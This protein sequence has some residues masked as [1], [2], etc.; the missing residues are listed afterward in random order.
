[1]Q[2][3]PRQTVLGQQSIMS[4]ATL[5]VYSY[6]DLPMLLLRCAVEP[7]PHASV[8]QQRWYMAKA[9]GCPIKQGISAKG[10]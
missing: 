5:L 8:L 3:R 9:I 7:Q 10:Q 4:I 1:M 6:Y 2:L